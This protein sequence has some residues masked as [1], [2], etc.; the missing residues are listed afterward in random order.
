MFYRGSIIKSFEDPLPVLPKK[1]K[2]KK[3]EKEKK[4]RLKSLLLILRKAKC[5]SVSLRTPESVMMCSNRI[6]EKFIK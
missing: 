4:N 5:Y 1:A 6:K 3:K 2:K